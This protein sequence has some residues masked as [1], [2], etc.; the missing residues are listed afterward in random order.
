MIKADDNNEY[1]NEYNGIHAYTI[2]MFEA[3]RYRNNFTV[4]LKVVLLYTHCYG[5]RNT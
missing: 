1:L 5:F 2:I 4:T 3:M